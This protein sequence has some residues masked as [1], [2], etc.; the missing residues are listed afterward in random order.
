MIIYAGL[1]GCYTIGESLQRIMNQDSRLPGYVEP[2]AVVEQLVKYSDFILNRDNSG[3]LTLIK[4][5]YTDSNSSF[6]YDSL[7]E[8]NKFRL[9]VYKRNKVFVTNPESADQLYQWAQVTAL[10]SVSDFN[11]AI[12]ILKVNSL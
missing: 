7:S 4:S 10:Q 5:R 9:S 8:F 3:L 11:D 12:S 2:P 6:L 1:L